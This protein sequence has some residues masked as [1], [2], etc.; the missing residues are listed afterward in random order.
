[1]GGAAGPS[2]DRALGAP[3]GAARQP[4]LLLGRRLSWS[5][6]DASC[7]EQAP[8]RA[9]LR[10][11]SNSGAETGA[12]TPSGVPPSQGAEQRERPRRA[13]IPASV[14]SRHSRTG[15]IFRRNRIRAPRA[16][17]AAYAVRPFRAL[18]HETENLVG[19][20]Q[21]GWGL[22]RPAAGA[23]TNLGVAA[24]GTRSRC[25]CSPPSRVDSRSA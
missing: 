22:C 2:N 12:G 17:R 5:W 18:P 14:G 25:R 8:P 24:P 7:L 15:G 11:W 1:L 3:W 10:V 13:P 23:R 21:R 9:P 6:S 19:C 4:P 16:S 20:D